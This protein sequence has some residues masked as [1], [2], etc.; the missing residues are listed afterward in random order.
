[1]KINLA[2]L[3]IGDGFMSPQDSSIYAEYLFQAGLVGE[4]ERDELLADE[5]DMKNYC[6]RG[7]YYYAWQ[8]IH[9][10]AFSSSSDFPQSQTVSVCVLRIFNFL[11]NLFIFCIFPEN[12]E[13]QLFCGI[14]SNIISCCILPSY[15]HIF[16]AL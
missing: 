12:S 8:V 15:F 7:D 9:T 5:A 4:R 16:S 2:G 3:G 14:T 10:Y 13:R 6:S 11:V 1:M